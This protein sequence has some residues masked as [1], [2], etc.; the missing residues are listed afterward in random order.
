MREPSARRPAHPRPGQRAET[1]AHSR[2]RLLDAALRILDE[3]GEAALTTTLVTKEAG[4][5]QPSFYVHFDNMDHLLGCLVEE[6]LDHWRAAPIEARRASREAPRDRERFRDTF[7]TPI[8]QLSAH[9][10]MFRLLLRS[11]LDAASPIGAWSRGMFDRLRDQLVD[12]LAAAGFE[13]RTPGERR[14]LQMIAD[15]IMGMTAE[16]AIGH[17]DGRYTDVEEMIDV[18]EAFSVGYLALRPSR[19]PDGRS[20]KAH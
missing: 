11:R 2:R 7:R 6:I 19:S 17:L 15:G 18:L 10:R 9:P 16:L 5:A 20:R 14:R 1:K 13:H 3:Q 4:L 12:D 8:A